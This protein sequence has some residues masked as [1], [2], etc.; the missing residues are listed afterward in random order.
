[1]FVPSQIIAKCRLCL[2]LL[3]C[4]LSICV[5]SFIVCVYKNLVCDECFYYWVFQKWFHQK[6]ILNNLKK[7]LIKMSF[8]KQISWEY[9]NNFW[10]IR[11]YI[12]NIFFKKHSYTYSEYLLNCLFEYLFWIQNKSILYKTEYRYV[13]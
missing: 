4:H 6:L 1:M 12:L 2:K 3:C 9:L 10:S 8:Y 11:K 7:K 5:L 13:L